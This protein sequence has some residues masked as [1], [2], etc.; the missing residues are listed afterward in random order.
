MSEKTPIKTPFFYGWIIVIVAGLAAYFSGPG[1][2]YTVSV[3]IDS[4]INEFGWSRTTVSSMY[5]MGTFAAGMLMGIIGKLLDK[6]GHRKIASIIAVGTGIAFFFMSMVSSVPM[7]LIGFFLIRLLSQGS[8]GLISGTMVPQWFIKRKGRA[9]SIVSV[10]GALS[11]ASYPAI[12]IWL[13][14]RFGWQNGWRTWTIVAWLVVVPLFYFFIRNR[15]EDVGLYPDNEKPVE[16][17]GEVVIIEEEAWTLQEALR[18][19]SFWLVNY[20]TVIPSAIITGC[21]FHQIS[22]LGQSGLSPETAALISTVTSL[23]NLPIALLAGGLADKYPLRYLMAINQGLLLA[24]VAALYYA[25][26]LTL[27]LVYGAFMGIMMG[28]QAI[29]RGV[30]W[31]EYFGRKHLSTIRGVNMMAGVIGSA[32]GPLPYGYAYDLFGGYSEVLLASMIFPLL[33]IF[34]GY[35]AKKPEKID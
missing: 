6:Y 9:M 34:L 15:P 22:I 20:V 25:D 33:G 31:P 26:S 23:I 18:T 8:M 5:S 1:Q 11:M 28:M 21:V 19:R 24:M 29:V 13:I 16:D 4:Y 14:Q 17:N 3:Y 10:F 7:L 2:T 35:L 27:V 32:L 12:N 30:V